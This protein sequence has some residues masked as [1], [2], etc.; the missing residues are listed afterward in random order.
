MRLYPLILLLGLIFSLTGCLERSDAMAPM[1][2]IISPANG[3]ANNADNIT[4]KGYA[5]DDSGI[6]AIRV[7]QVDL[8][9]ASDY[10]KSEKGKR[11]IE[12][13]FQTGQRVD[14]FNANIVVED[15]S[16]RTFTLPYEL[17]IDTVPPTIEAVVTQALDNGNINVVGVAR[18]NN[19]VQ[20]IEIAGVAPAFVTQ[21]EQAF[22][23]TVPASE[24][25]QI[26]V[27][28]SAGNTTTQAIP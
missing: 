22:D 14:K 20:S 1:I 5:M 9:N 15:V 28:D 26:V 7:D 21:A 23:I 19:A 8:L 16:G 12:F 3:T 13:A 10:Y 25:M 11:L 27:K 17:V 24:N 4:V 18:D 6:R 2:T